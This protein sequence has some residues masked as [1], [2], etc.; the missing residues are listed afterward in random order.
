MI[1]LDY[2]LSCPLIS[3]EANT[4]TY[5]G[6]VLPVSA[7][8]ITPFAVIEGIDQVAATFESRGG[9]GKVRD[10]GRLAVMWPKRMLSTSLFVKIVLRR[11]PRMNIP[12]ANTKA[13]KYRHR[14]CKDVETRRKR[15]R[16]FK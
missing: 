9:G 11:S 3:E 7:G 2:S 12:I 1:F 8:C 14:Y 10:Q 4:R 5:T 15:S 13:E 6:H 16:E